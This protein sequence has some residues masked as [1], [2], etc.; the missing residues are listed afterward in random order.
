MAFFSVLP[1][2]WWP[3][4]QGSTGTAIIGGSDRYCTHE[5][6]AELLLDALES[7]T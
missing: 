4:A 7:C 5:P 2:N 3:G 6:I 1:G